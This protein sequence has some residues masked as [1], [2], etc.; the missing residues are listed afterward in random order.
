MVTE[1]SPAQVLDE[2]TASGLRGRGGAAFPVGRKWQFAAEAPGERKY[3]VCNGG[4]DEPG[5]RKD[6]LLME[7]YPHRRR[8]GPP[9]CAE[10]RGA[11]HASRWET[12]ACGGGRASLEGALAEARE[13]G[14]LG[15]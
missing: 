8:G 11:R 9:P 13:A 15:E 3:V 5:S 12:G 2:V 6:R 4:E 14:Y 1:G 7:T 10:R